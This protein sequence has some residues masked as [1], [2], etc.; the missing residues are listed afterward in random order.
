MIG[1]SASRASSKVKRSAG[2]MFSAPTDLRMRLA[3]TGRSSTPRDP[4][5]I[6][7]RL[8]KVLLKE[9]HRLRSQ[10]ATGFDPE[11]VHLRRRRRADA[12]EFADRQNLDEGR[13]HIRRD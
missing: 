10:I 6:G 13:P 9:R 12:V 2:N 5:V 3:R 11:L 1:K 4:I 7:L 8:T